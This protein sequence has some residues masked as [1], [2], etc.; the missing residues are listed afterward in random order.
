[1]AIL[2]AL[3]AA[4]LRSMGSILNTAFGWATLTLFGRSPR[5]RQTA[6][7][8]LSFGSVIWIIA[9]C[10]A[11]W[12][13]FS[14]FLLAFVTVPDFLKPWVR[15]LMLL[16]VAVVPLAIGLATRR[17]QNDS[18]RKGSAAEVTAAMLRGY[19]YALGFGLTFVMLLVLVPLSKLR[20]VIRGWTTT[21]I[22]VVVESSDY[23]GVLDELHESLRERGIET[24]LERVSWVLRAPTRVLG[25]FAG[26][27]LAA[28][29][30]EDM[31][32]MRAEN[33]EI[34]LHPSDLVVAGR[35][36]RTAPAAAVLLERL[37]YTRAH[38]TWD[39]ESQRLEERLHAI[40]KDALEHRAPAGAAH[41]A[42][43]ASGSSDRRLRN[44]ESDLR[45]T[46]LP[47]EE[48]EKLF[49]IK[50]QVETEVLRAARASMA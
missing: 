13:S 2:Q 7:S 11:I 15:A 48:I 9:L 14:T 5:S 46:H 43:V 17:L 27:S 44:V 47:Y 23:R 40:L 22:P 36:E 1:M 24:R 16:L 26:R 6:L 32:A 30:S 41:A 28:L 4:L 33:L 34:L 39:E 18:G 29:V 25:L 10:G 20:D 50:L 12:P 38:L 42:E 49:R 3:I 19:S 35:P 21:H 45:R 37:L 8:I 31:K